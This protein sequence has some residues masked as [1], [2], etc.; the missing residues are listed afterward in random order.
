[1]NGEMRTARPPRGWVMTDRGGH[2]PSEN[3]YIDKEWLLPQLHREVEKELGRPVEIGLLAEVVDEIYPGQ[4][5]EWSGSG[6]IEVW[7]SRRAMAAF[8]RRSE[9][10]SR[11]EQEAYVRARRAEREQ[12]LAERREDIRHG[13]TGRKQDWSPRGAIPGED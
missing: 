1:M 12:W 2:V 11:A 13:R 9:V 4:E 10:R 7:V 6:K 3:T 8:E 5:I